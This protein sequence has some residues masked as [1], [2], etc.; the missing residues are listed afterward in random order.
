MYAAPP[1]YSVNA[2]CYETTYVFSRA[3][4]RQ[5]HVLSARETEEELYMEMEMTAR[6]AMGE[7]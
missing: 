6:A 3:C 2:I 5:L 1:Q 7:V 4:L